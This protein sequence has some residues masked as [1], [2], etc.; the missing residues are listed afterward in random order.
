[1]VA[2]FIYNFIRLLKFIKIIVS[3]RI[4]NRRVLIGDLKPKRKVCISR[5]TLIR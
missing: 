2:K 4:V 5:I 1:M 3:E